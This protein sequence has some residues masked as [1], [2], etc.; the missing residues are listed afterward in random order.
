[1]TGCGFLKDDMDI[2]LPILMTE[3]DEYIRTEIVNKN[4]A[5]SMSSEKTRK[6][7]LSEFRTRYRAVDR[8]F[9]DEYLSVTD[10]QLQL[11][12]QM[13]VMLKAYRLFHELQMNLVVPK[14]H[15]ADP[16][17]S[18]NDVLLGIEDIGQ[19]DEFVQ[20]WSKDTKSKVASCFMTMLKKVGMYDDKSGKLKQISLSNDQW[21]IFLS[22]GESWF[23]EACFLLPFEIKNIE[24]HYR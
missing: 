8:G 4:T 16:R 6:R 2:I 15:S 11:L 18:R 24:E 12:A 17:L 13:Y 3:D 14:W 22:R 23:L 1:M 20:N 19:K 9:W 10:T 21:N 7:A 5:L